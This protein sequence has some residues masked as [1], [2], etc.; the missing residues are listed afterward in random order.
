MK[1]F[2]VIL[3]VL[4]LAITGVF[5]QGAAEQAKK[6][7]KFIGLTSSRNQTLLCRNLLRLIQLRQV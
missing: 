5:A 7:E 1:K 3:L 6:K 4:A 2:T